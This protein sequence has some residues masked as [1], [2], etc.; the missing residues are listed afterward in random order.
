M[1]KAPT[2]GEPGSR[3]EEDPAR[4]SKSR[5][6]ANRPAAGV[7]GQLAPA[8]L[9]EPGPGGKGAAAADRSHLEPPSP[10]SSGKP[11]AR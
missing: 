8:H 9:T 2:Y 5:L 3:S 10:L 7:D 11:A 6:T 1:P 4:R